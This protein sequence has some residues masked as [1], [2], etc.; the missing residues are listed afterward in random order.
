MTT[1]GILRATKIG[2][3]WDTHKEILVPIEIEMSRV[4]SMTPDHTTIPNENGVDAVT[5]TFR[6]RYFD[7]ER[8]H[9]KLCY[10]LPDFVIDE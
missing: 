8:K 1:T 9:E 4:I 7:K 10:I 5:K 2:V 6:C 3:D